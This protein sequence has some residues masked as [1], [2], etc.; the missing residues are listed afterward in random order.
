MYEPNPERLNTD[1]KMQKK[2]QPRLNPMKSLQA[3]IYKFF[4]LQSLVKAGL[5]EF[6]LLILFSLR[7]QNLKMKTSASGRNSTTPGATSDLKNSYTSL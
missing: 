1:L 3:C 2:F 4:L 6:N 5:V 7:T